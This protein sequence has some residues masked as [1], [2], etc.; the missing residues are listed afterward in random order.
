[1]IVTLVER[2]NPVW[3]DWFGE[4]T[5]FLA[6]RLGDVAIRIEH[7]ASTSVPGMAAKPIIDID[8]VVGPSQVPEAIRRLESAGYIHQGASASRL[9]P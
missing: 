6:P 7:V 1:M 5:S 3:V 4:I 2:Y 8:M 9:K